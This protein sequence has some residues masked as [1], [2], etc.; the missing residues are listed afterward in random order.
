MEWIAGGTDR[1]IVCFRHRWRAEE[2]GG[3]CTDFTDSPEQL[4]EILANKG[5]EPTRPPQDHG[6]RQIEPPRAIETPVLALSAATND[7]CRAVAAAYRERWMAK[8]REARHKSL[9]MLAAI[10]QCETDAG[11]PTMT[12]EERQWFREGYSHADLRLAIIN[13]EP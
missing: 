9:T 13:N 11:S 10:R 5:P 3:L 8:G 12:D 1:E 7:E 6:S 4:M 2:I